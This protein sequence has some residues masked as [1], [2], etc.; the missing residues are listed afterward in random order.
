MRKVFRLDTRSNYVQMDT[1]FEVASMVVSNPTASPV[2]IRTGAY[3]Q[4]TSANADIIVPAGE[5]ESFPVT[6]Y[7][8]AAAFGNVSAIPPQDIPQ[9]GLFQTCVIIL[10]DETEKTPTYGSASF[11]S[12]STSPLTPNAG[13][14]AYTGT[15]TSPVY[16]M[17]AWG[18]ALLLLAPDAVGV[19]GQAIVTLLSSATGIAGSFTTIGQWAVWPGVPAVIQVPRPAR[20]FQF[21][22]TTTS[23]P[24]E[25]NWSGSYIVRASLA[26]ILA[27][28]YTPGTSF[29]TY[30][31]NVAHLGST[32]GIFC[33]LGFPAVT[34]DLTVTSVGSQGTVTIEG[35]SAVG[36]PWAERITRERS[37]STALGMSMERTL[38]NPDPYMRVTIAQTDAGTAGGITG[39]FALAIRAQTDD[40]AV[41]SD[42]FETLG[43][44]AQ[45][46]NTGQSIYHLLST[47]S[48]GVGTLHTDLVN[49]L[50]QDTLI[51]TNLGVVVSSLTAINSSLS[52]IHADL[53][54]TIHPDLTTINT[55]LGTLATHNDL[56]T[57]NT[58]LNTINTSLATVNTNLGTINTTLGTT[59]T[60]LSTIST[61]IATIVA[62]L[63][64]TS[65]MVIGQF[66]YNSAA[67]AYQQVGFLLVQGSYL[68]ACMLGFAAVTGAFAAGAFAGVIML[69]AYGPVG[70]AAQG[71]YEGYAGVT[72]FNNA[73]APAI[74]IYQGNIPTMKYDS[75]RSPGLVI[76]VNNQYLYLA[77]PPIAGGLNML[78][79]YT[80]S[81]T[82]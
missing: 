67:G 22:L 20:Y 65:Y 82:V 31:F 40:T 78:I 8:F 34:F 32:S 25:P 66:N 39:S 62:A 77:G 71:F 70:G 38:G 27:V 41:L 55:T 24:G 37:W 48:S 35:S 21:T 58:T 15:T 79:A 68:Q 69:A 81:L 50:T 60:T 36:G 11:L 28:G 63:T 75:I 42:I 16:D 6:G 64:R 30:V 26:E 51:N 3:D 59:N 5:S 7:A 18:G 9:S 33:A 74:A 45:L 10:L 13:F 72:T 49:I 73:A 80:L 46:T 17:G 14:V 53:T 57:A 29:I 47:T 4:P 1:T 61:N 52:T 19:S 12:L 2:F 44:K 23:I 54:G 56:V 76:P 43:D